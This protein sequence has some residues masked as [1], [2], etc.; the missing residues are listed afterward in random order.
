MKLTTIRKQGY[1]AL[2]N[3]LGVVGM[4]RFLQQFDAGNGDYTTEKYQLDEPTLEDFQTFI[5]DKNSLSQ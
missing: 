4:L 2:V 5:K 3:S 1:Q